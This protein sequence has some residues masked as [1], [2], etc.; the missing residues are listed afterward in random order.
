MGY[1]VNADSTGTVK[2]LLSHEEK[3]LW[4]NSAGQITYTIQVKAVLLPEVFQNKQ[5]VDC[6]FHPK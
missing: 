6:K 1:T 5:G 2:N 4:L 3:T